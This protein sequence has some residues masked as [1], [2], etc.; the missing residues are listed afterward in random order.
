MKTDTDIL[1][2]LIVDDS[3]IFRESLRE[4]LE[5]HDGVEIVGNAKNGLEAIDLAR[6]TAPDIIFMD[7]N[8]PRMNGVDAAIAIKRDFPEIKVYFVTVHEEST[9]KALAE[10]I[11]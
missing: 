9:Y 4:F 5:N 3:D 8:M 2:I 10:I 11:H 7:I 1:R 6:L